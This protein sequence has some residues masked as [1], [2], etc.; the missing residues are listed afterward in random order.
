VFIENVIRKNLPPRKRNGETA[1]VLQTHERIRE[2]NSL[3]VCAASSLHRQPSGEMQLSLTTSIIVNTDVPGTI[4]QQAEEEHCDLIALAT[5]GR[6]AL[7]RALMGSVTERVIGHTTL[8]LLVT[9]PQEPIMESKEADDPVND[10]KESPSWMG[11][12]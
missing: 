11:L 10:E 4:I 2:L 3:S 9:R 7:M 8:P 1:Q 5:H 6:G 12:L